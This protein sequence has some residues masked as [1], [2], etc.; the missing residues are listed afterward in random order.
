MVSYV[1]RECEEEERNKLEIRDLWLTWILGEISSLYYKYISN[2]LLNQTTI[3][4]L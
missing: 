2:F 4:S 3:D 1:P